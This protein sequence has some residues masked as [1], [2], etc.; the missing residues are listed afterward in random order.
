MAHQELGSEPR[1]GVTVATAARGVASTTEC[2]AALA[3]ADATAAWAHSNVVAADDDDGD[4][5]EGENDAW[6]AAADDEDNDGDNDGAPRGAAWQRERNEAVRT[7]KT[8]W[9]VDGALPAA[10]TRRATAA[11]ELPASFAEKWQLARSLSFS[12]S[13]VCRLPFVVC[14]LSFVVCRLSFVVCRLSLLPRGLVGRQ[15]TRTHIPPSAMPSRSCPPG[16]LGA[17]PRSPPNDAVRPRRI[18]A[19]SG[20]WPR[21][22]FRY[23]P[24]QQYTPH[25]DH[26][27]SFND[28]VPGGRLA[29][30]IV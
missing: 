2:D 14:R 20:A 25:T 8:A 7:S 24:G 18:W 6:G 13:F 11:A 12:F 16:S 9:L 23:A 1:R 4:D 15:T 27:D 29:T 26:V 17:L 3:A 28:L 22:C 5:D 21:S 30:L 19:G 10:L